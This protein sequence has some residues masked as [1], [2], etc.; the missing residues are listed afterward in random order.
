MDSRR[1]DAGEVESGLQ[2]GERAKNSFV[3]V[4]VTGPAKGR[5]L[6]YWCEFGDAAVIN[7][8]TRQLTPEIAELAKQLDALVDAPQ[9][10]LK[11]NKAFLVLLT[12][13][14]ETAEQ[15]LKELDARHEV[16]RVP[17]T[18]FDGLRGPRG[19]KI[20]RRAEVTVMM[21]RN[22]IVEFNAAFGPREFNKDSVARVVAGAK[23]FL[24]GKLSSDK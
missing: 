9:D 17:F 21:W 13:D 11:P 19:Y 24:A 23:E 7:V 8:Q 12:D 14:P 2:I 3:V 6:C 22:N 4:D 15:E 18:F 10:H 16:E 5:E 1:L 20:A